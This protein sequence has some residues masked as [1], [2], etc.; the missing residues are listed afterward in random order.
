MGVT[1]ADTWLTRPRPH[2]LGRL[3]LVC[4]SYAGADGLTLD[5]VFLKALAVLRPSR[6]LFG[7]D[8]SFFPRGRQ[9]SVYEEQQRATAALAPADRT[10][11]FSGNFVRLFPER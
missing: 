6:L 7:T 10:A 5:R 8:S 2:G 9:R 1:R 3:Q 11:I 4:F